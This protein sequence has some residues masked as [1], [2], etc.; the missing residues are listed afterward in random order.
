MF[1]SSEK[2][3]NI[4]KVKHNKTPLR[5]AKFLYIFYAMKRIDWNKT[6]DCLN[7]D[8]FRSNTTGLFGW[9]VAQKKLL[10]LL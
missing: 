5:E 4:K 9:Q 2:V 8:L 3:K 6:R 7:E 10:L 1:I